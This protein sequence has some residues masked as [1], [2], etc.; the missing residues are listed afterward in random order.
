[1]P[2]V[3]QV[4]AAADLGLIA[5]CGDVDAARQALVRLVELTNSDAGSLV[6]I[7]GPGPGPRC[8]PTLVANVEYPRDAAEGFA[9]QLTRS[10]WMP[11][12]ENSR[13]APSVSR[14]PTQTFRR[15][16]IFEQ[17]VA[18]AGFQDGVSAALRHENRTVGLVHL[19]SSHPRAFHDAARALVTAVLA[20]LTVLVQRSAVDDEI[21][22]DA[23]ALFL[24]GADGGLVGRSHTAVMDDPEVRQLAEEA[25]AVGPG[26]IGFMHPTSA[27]WCRV[28]F[29]VADVAAPR[30]VTVRVS[31]PVPVMGL[32]GRELEVLTRMT[33][34]LTNDEIAADLFLSP[35][36]VHRHVERILA[37]TQTRNRV[38]AV[39]LALREGLLRP[40]P[41][42]LAALMTKHASPPN[43]GGPAR[44][45]P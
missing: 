36:T 45:T 39:S 2:S 14:E 16:W 23:A 3:S 21:S 30:S 7:Q 12:V 34:G 19:A 25:A 37:R 10:H 13:L 31:E 24:R 28:T 33:L 5:G 20:P 32:T 35:R 8:T 18:P 11:V 42:R 1:M 22:V 43:W 4:A 27:G 17:Y 6:A 26:T 38:E 41:G 29:A 44:S 9:Q 15:G 40:P